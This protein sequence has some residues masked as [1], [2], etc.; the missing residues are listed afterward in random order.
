M[1]IGWPVL[2][3]SRTTVRS[4]CGQA[5]IAPSGVADQSLSR[6]LA[7]ISP[8]PA[9][10][11]RVLA[12]W[13]EPSSSKVYN[14]DRYRASASPFSGSSLLAAR[15]RD[16]PLLSSAWG[17]GHV[18]LPFS[19]RGR[20][21]VFGLELPLP[22]DTTFVA[23]LRYGL[24]SLHLRVEQIAPSDAEATRSVEAL[25]SLV[26]LIQAI[27]PKVDAQA[28]KS[29]AA[30]VQEF[31]SSIKIEQRKDRAVLTANL[32]LELLRKMA[33]STNDASR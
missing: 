6:I 22:E 25:G 15:Y 16:V 18:G 12:V 32:P 10:A 5:S 29:D 26:Q 30:A 23:S 4:D 11:R 24:G 13:R 17:I 9:V 1:Y 21:T 8:P 7:P 2:S 27:Q 14:P 3:I 28:D 19:E 20:I 31:T 33:T